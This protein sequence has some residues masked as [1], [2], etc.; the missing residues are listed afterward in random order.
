M[1]DQESVKTQPC[2]IKMALRCVEMPQRQQG[3]AKN[4]IGLNL[5]EE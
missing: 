3:E 4:R 1:P 2:R 5:K